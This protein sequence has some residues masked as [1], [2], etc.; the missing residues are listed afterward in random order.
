MKIKEF[1]KR[2]KKE[3][4]DLAVLY[5]ME[6]NLENVNM[7]YLANYSGYG[8]LLAPANGK[9][10]LFVPLLDV[11]KAWKSGTRFTI[12]RKNFYDK[13]KEFAGKPKV[14]GIE[15]RKF[16]VY[17]Q[18]RFR[19]LF[20]K[21][22][23]RDVSSIISDLRKIKT[24]KEIKIIREASLIAN[25]I[26]DSCI[27]NLKKFRT[28][29]EIYNY[30]RIECIKH[31]VEPSFDFVVASGRNPAT[32]HHEPNEEKIHKGFCVIDFGVRYKG[33]C[34]DMTRTVYIGKPSGNETELYN[35]VL[36]VQE[37]AIKSIALGKKFSEIDSE[38]RKNLGK[39]AKYFIHSLGHGIGL[40]VHEEPHVGQG[41]KDAVQNGMI[42][43]IE[44]GVYM[45][46]RR[47]IRIEDD[48]L[49]LN[50]K[51]ENLSKVGKKLVI[52]K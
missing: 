37:K 26:L 10:R 1:Q 18:K 29:K 33:Y 52:V 51:A 49:V 21:V 15:E 19:K 23:F 28:E 17:A 34:T 42:F 5:N 31:N 4:I 20:G 44:P 41:S 13:I 32:P 35:L 22:K 12:I 40:E 36:S 24:E 43:T 39:Y 11:E 27:K 50:G 2:L 6:T 14:I 47:G 8:F 3:K 9:Q 16:S 45:I 7:R 46:G 48:I 25:K 38:A 30:L